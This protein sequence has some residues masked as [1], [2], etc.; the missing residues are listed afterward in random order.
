MS[1]YDDELPELTIQQIGVSEEIQY[2]LMPTIM[3]FIDERPALLDALD[4]LL[5]A[6]QN[7]SPR[8]LDIYK[9]SW[10]GTY[11]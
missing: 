6:L 10:R 9:E 7:E 4:F 8:E 5:T 2:R 1:K 11:D 3:E